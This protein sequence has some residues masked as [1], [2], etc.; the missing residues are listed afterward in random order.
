M[1]CMYTLLSNLSFRSRSP[2]ISES[3]NSRANRVRRD[4]LRQPRSMGS[5]TMELNRACRNRRHSSTSLFISRK[6]DEMRMETTERTS[7]LWC[8]P[9]VR[10]E[11][12][13]KTPTGTGAAH[14]H[15]ARTKLGRRVAVVDVLHEPLEDV[16]VTVHA[17]VNVVTCVVAS[18]VIPKVAHLCQQQVAPAHKVAID[19]AV[20]VTD[21]DDDRAFLGTGLRAATPGSR[22]CLRVRTRGGCIGRS[23]APLIACRP[24]LVVSVRAAG[25]SVAVM[26][27]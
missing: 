26:A 11:A 14:D 4:W 5:L 7:A 8:K 23:A 10:G 9:G 16:H 18:Q 3:L 6:L 20:F 22:P 13:E 27:A 1:R 2:S 21:V 15:T 24:P 19:L 17:D 25:M 12:R